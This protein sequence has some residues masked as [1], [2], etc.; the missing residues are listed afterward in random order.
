MSVP[1][2]TDLTTEEI[3]EWTYPRKAFCKDIFIPRGGIPRELLFQGHMTFVADVTGQG[4][5]AATIII[6]A[7]NGGAGVVE[8]GTITLSGSDF[9][10]DGFA[11]HAIYDQVR[12]R[13]TAISGT[14]AVLNVRMGV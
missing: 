6:E 9:F 13:V 7:S 10:S 12:A 3:G 8:L 14:E 2:F 5:V 1:L 11:A 4:A